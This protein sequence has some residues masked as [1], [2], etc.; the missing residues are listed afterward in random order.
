MREYAAL[1]D[2]ET[3]AVW[4][5][6]KGDFRSAGPAHRQRE[7]FFDCCFGRRKWRAFIEH[8]LDIHGAFGRKEMFRTVYMGAER[9]P[10]LAD[11]AQRRKRHHLK[12]SGIGQDRP[13]P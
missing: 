3:S 11:L 8:H 6:A 10:L 13:L 4:L 2:A 12:A 5:L 9:Y 7:R 1:H